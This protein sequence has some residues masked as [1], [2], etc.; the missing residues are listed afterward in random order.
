MK[1]RRTGAPRQLP[2][3][4]GAIRG[5]VALSRPEGD[6]DGAAWPISSQ[7]VGVVPASAPITHAATDGCAKNDSGSPVAQATLRGV[8]LTDGARREALHLLRLI[9]ELE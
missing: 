7:L 4:T 6:Y 1:P 9:A 5:A 2:G 8:N 3:T